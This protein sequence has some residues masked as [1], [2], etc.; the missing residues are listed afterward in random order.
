MLSVGH[1]LYCKFKVKM[2]VFLHV[3]SYV[4]KVYFPKMRYVLD[5]PFGGRKIQFEKVKYLFPS[6]A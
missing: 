5:I 2:S 3:L 6:I 4:C 1:Q